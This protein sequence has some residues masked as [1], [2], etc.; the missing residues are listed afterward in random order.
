MLY[1]IQCDK[2]LKYVQKYE[3]TQK[4][5]KKERKIEKS[6]LKPNILAQAHRCPH[7]AR[8]PARA[9]PRTPA[10]ARTYEKVSNKLRKYEKV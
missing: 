1:F 9:S 10:Q 6:I 3:N 2:S 5:R 8:P 7:T 4:V